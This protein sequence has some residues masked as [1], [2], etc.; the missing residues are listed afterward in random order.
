MNIKIFHISRSTCE[1]FDFSKGQAFEC[2]HCYKQ[3]YCN[4]HSY[5]TFVLLLLSFSIVQLRLSTH[6][7]VY[8]N[9]DDDVVHIVYYLVLFISASVLVNC[10]FLYVCIF[11]YH[12][13]E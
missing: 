8:D 6:H 5:F 13:C 3:A 2:F 9:D 11:C 7:K 1:Y 10:I 12:F 4:R